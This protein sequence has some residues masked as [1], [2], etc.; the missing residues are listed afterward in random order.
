MRLPR[1][2]ELRKARPGDASGVRA[3]V[4]Q[5]GYT[6]DPRAFTETFTQV[7]RHPE[8]SV[9]VLAEGVRVIGYLAIS[10]RPQIRLGGRVATIDELA[11]DA[12]HR[13]R[14]FGSELL[15]QALEIARGLA[16]VRIEVAT[17]RARDSFARGFYRKHGFVE[18][19]TALLRQP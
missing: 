15:E 14:G 9:L 7:V 13:G 3:L 8:A 17:S 12:D 4:E 5:L 16:C 6:P 11:L 1:G 10:H 19:D 18:V 2:I